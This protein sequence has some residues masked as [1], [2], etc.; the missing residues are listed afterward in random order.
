MTMIAGKENLPA[1]QVFE[2]VRVLKGMPAGQFVRTMDQVYAAGLGFQ[3]TTCHTP[4]RYSDSTRTKATARK[5]AEMTASI[6]TDLMKK[7]FPTGNQSVNCVSCHRGAR[8]PARTMPGLAGPGRG[9][10]SGR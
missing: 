10:G 8:T 3:C 6:N 7:V 4:G 2:D 5:M 9:G 1:E